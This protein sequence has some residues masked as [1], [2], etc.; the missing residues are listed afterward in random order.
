MNFSLSLMSI[1]CSSRLPW[2]WFT[3]L[4]FKAKVLREFRQRPNSDKKASYCTQFKEQ[5]PKRPDVRLGSWRQRSFVMGRITVVEGALSD[6]L[7]SKVWW[8]PEAVITEQINALLWLLLHNICCRLPVFSI[9]LK[10]N[11]S[12][13]VSFFTELSHSSAILCPACYV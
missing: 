5:N 2:K 12:S 7:W 13:P 3:V 6:H 4:E 8:V 11:G 9:E 10:F 1:F